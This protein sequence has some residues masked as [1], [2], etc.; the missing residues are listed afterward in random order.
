MKIAFTGV[1]DL[2]NY[3]EHVFPIIFKSECDKRSIDADIYLFSCFENKYVFGEEKN[4]YPMEE[5]EAMHEQLHFDLVV[6][7]GGEIIHYYKFEHQLNGDTVLYPMYKIWVIPSLVCYKHQIPV[8]WNNPGVPFEFEPLF[9][10]IT[11]QVLIYPSYLSVRNP[12]SVSCIEKYRTVNKVHC[13][14]DTAFL[15]S[16]V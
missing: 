6:I 8:V 2:E 11:E 1:F 13:N 14:P 9:S 3:G 15:L 12:F 4:V 16:Q 5:L 7:G 10:E